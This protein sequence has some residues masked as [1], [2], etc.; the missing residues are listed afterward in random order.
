LRVGALDSLEAGESAFVVE[1]VEVLEGL[2]DRRGEV[3]G[4]GMGGGVEWLRAGWRL[5]QEGKEESRDYFCAV[6]YC[7]SPVRPDMSGTIDCLRKNTVLPRADA[8]NYP[9][10]DWTFVPVDYTLG[11]RRS[12]SIA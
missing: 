5:K 9:P 6:L 7:C 12:R 2:A 3:D 4:I 11:H 10:M 8:G 1:V